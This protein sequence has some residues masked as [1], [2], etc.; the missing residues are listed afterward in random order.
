MKTIKNV[1][2]FIKAF[3][4]KLEVLLLHVEDLHYLFKIRRENEDFIRNTLV[5]RNTGKK[6][7]TVNG[8]TK[9]VIYRPLP[10]SHKRI[11][12]MSV[13][14]LEQEEPADENSCPPLI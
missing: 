5:I 8:V 1:I 7:L 14:N 13:N 6:T 2:I 11:Y 10:P 3:L 12:V 4:N 9:L